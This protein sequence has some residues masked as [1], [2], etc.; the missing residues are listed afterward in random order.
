MATLETA[1]P[2]MYLLFDCN[3][4]F[5]SCE[6][7]FRPDWRNRPL[8]VLSNNDGC[9]VS[10]SREAKAAGIAM[11]EPY[12]KCRERLER[13]GGVVCSG[14]FALYNDLSERVMRILEE[15]LPETQQYSIDEAFGVV[16][17]TR[18]WVPFC[19][20]LRRRIAHWTGI[21]VSVGIAPTR[22][23]AKLANERAKKE[24][25]HA[26]VLALVT[27]GET[28]PYLEQ[29]P[30]EDVWGIGRRLAP[31]LRGMGF[32]TAA[33]V[34][35]ADL[36]RLRRAFGVH[37]E[38][39][40]LELR[41]LPCVDEEDGETERT[42]VM[43]SRT[44]KEGIRD[45]ATLRDALSRFTEK[46]GRI[47]RREGLMASSL[48]VILRTSRYEQ[49]E[50]LAC[51]SAGVPLPCPTDDSRVFLRAASALLEGLFR[52]GYDYRKLGVMLAD[53]QAASSVQ[54]TFEHP[55]VATS[56][57]MTV[58]DK[59]QAAGHPIH[60]ASSSAAPLWHSDHSSPEY[61]TRWD[62]LPEA[63]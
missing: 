36:E 23:L 59:L 5:A 32:R 40:A 42:Q 29:S 62:Q 25:R 1:S 4:F 60:F 55:E 63:H 8:V 58:L 34:A 39:L 15:A 2:L 26:G 52:E 19:R 56:P 30:L 44:M 21:T 7:V 45:I 14:N 49:A 6:Q 31:R 48:Y 18:D 11:G 46:A 22:T 43:V 53:L 16:D 54:P 3:N 28:L 51:D 38:R 33:D 13:I 61:T 20:S 12:F 27:P 9:V 37:G 57:L 41:G 24:E 35:R 17:D 47:L 50:H 10:R